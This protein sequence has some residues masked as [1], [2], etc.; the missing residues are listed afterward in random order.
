M[1]TTD[2]HH[3]SRIVKNLDTR[4]VRTEGIALPPPSRA[5]SRETDTAQRANTA[6]PNRT[7]CFR[8][9]RPVARTRP[10]SL[11]RHQIPAGSARR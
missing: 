8:L 1:Q 4:G 7:P 2:T 6:K 9:E 10:F 5:R 11:A 3:V